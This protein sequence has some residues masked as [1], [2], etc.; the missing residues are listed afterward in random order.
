MLSRPSL[1][2]V[3][4]PPESMGGS[5]GELVRYWIPGDGDDPE[6]PNC[7]RVPARRGGAL[8]LADVVAAF[9]L[10]GRYHFRFRCR[11]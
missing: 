2:C 6:H 7:F 9:P 10:P 3:S 8:C 11:K 5:G 1:L 4:K